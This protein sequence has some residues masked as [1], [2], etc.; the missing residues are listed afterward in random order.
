[1]ICE[2]LSD[3]TDADSFFHIPINFLCNLR[4]FVY[5]IDWNVMT[6]VGEQFHTQDISYRAGWDTNRYYINVRRR[7]KQL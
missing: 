6:G 5:N 2:K 1:M 7:Y 4:N 3:I